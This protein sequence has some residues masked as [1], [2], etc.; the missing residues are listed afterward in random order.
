[1]S[2]QRFLTVNSDSA[3]VSALIGKLIDEVKAKITVVHV[4]NVE[5]IEEVQAAV[6][7]EQPDVIFTASEWTAEQAQEINVIAKSV[8]AD[9]KTV[10]IPHGLATEQGP[11]AVA[12]FIQQS[13]AGLY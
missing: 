10:N 5:K 6:Q 11:E 13:V 1:M 8:K 3:R 9:I 12:A 4:G 7:K 2:T